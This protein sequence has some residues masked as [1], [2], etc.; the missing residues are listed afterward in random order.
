MTDDGAEIAVFKEWAQLGTSLVLV[1][2]G[3]SG[4]RSFSASMK[5]ANLCGGMFPSASNVVKPYGRVV[6]EAI[7]VIE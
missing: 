5:R 6:M 1:G 3:P 4:P 2:L 7:L